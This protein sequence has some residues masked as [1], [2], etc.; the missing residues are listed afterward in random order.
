MKALEGVLGPEHPDTLTCVN[1]LAG[2]LER[3]GDCAGAQRL[4]EWA[5]E[6][7]ERVLGRDHPDTL[8]SLNNLAGLLGSKGDFAG[9]QPLYERALDASE[10]VLGPEHPHTL[11]GLRNLAGLL[12]DKGDYAGAQPLY[13]QALETLLDI[14]VSSGSPHPDMQTLIYQYAHCLEKLGRSREE[15]RGLLNNVMRPFGMSLGGGAK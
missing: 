1:N 2:L 11:A 12:E 7:R 6:A 3:K 13:E 8:S 4:Y 5:L 14:S 15:V 9:A 10:R